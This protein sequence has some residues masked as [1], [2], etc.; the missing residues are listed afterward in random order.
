MVLCLVDLLNPNS[1]L[2]GG[3]FL[4]NK[5]L[6]IFLCGL[7]YQPQTGTNQNCFRNYH[8]I[9]VTFNK[10]AIRIISQHQPNSVQKT[11]R[12]LSWAHGWLLPFLLIK[13]TDSRPVIL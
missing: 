10:V 2:K 7:L 9:D 12:L 4:K 3:A 13:A 1:V 11:T 6:I 5:T 8:F